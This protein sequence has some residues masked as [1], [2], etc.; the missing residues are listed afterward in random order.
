MNWREGMGH[1]ARLTKS[2]RAV[3]RGAFL[4]RFAVLLSAVL[5]TWTVLGLGAALA[6]LA[7]R[8]VDRPQH[9]A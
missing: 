1:E 9:T 3:L 6:E 5:T 4:Q 2:V 7:C 8:V